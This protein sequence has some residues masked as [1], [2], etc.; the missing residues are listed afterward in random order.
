MIFKTR[1]GKSID[2]ETDLTAPERHI[3][4]KLL[5]WEEFAVTIEQFRQKAGEA[6]MKGWNNSGPIAQR[7]T[8]K[9]IL[10]HMEEKVL[11]RLKNKP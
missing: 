9:S 11:L 1:N 10:T 2:T 8:M 3:L 7:E 4:Q 5:V 6:L